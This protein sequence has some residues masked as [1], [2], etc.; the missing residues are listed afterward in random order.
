MQYPSSC[1][2]AVKDFRRMVGSKTP[3]TREKQLAERAYRHHN[4][5]QTNQFCRD[6]DLYDNET[7]SDYT[8]TAWDLW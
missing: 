3:P 4:T 7:Y 2:R 6:P 1:D 8:L 5:Q